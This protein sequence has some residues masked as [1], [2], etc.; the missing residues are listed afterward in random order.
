MTNSRSII[1]KYLSIYKKLEHKHNHITYLI[2][3][4]YFL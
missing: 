1:L 2:D 3:T 4:F